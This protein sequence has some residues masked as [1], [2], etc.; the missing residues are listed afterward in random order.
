MIACS[1]AQPSIATLITAKGGD[2]ATANAP[3]DVR[4]SKGGGGQCGIGVVHAFLEYTSHLPPPT[5]GHRRNIDFGAFLVARVNRM[6]NLHSAR[7]VQGRG[8]KISGR[9]DTAA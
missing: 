1:L 9:K 3:F 4:T 7:M 6:Y 5:L 8:G 2:L